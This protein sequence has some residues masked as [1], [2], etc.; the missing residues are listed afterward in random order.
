MTKT[1]ELIDKYIIVQDS[2][3][4]DYNPPSYIWTDNTGE[5]VRCADCE[6]YLTSID[7]PDCNLNGCLEFPEPDDYCSRGVRK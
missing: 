1:K 3:A 4:T 6:Y 7:L 2:Q 5:L